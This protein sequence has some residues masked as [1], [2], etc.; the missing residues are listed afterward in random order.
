MV[1]AS[2]L[3]YQHQEQLEERQLV[4][5]VEVVGEQLV[6]PC[7]GE[8]SMGESKPSPQATEIRP[9]SPYRT[10]TGDWQRWVYR[11]WGSSLVDVQD[12][13]HHGRGLDN[14]AG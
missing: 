11:C 4:D 10:K 8:P 7:Q 1:W 9:G 2:A 5:V 14:L 12:K 6:C 13:N 3:E